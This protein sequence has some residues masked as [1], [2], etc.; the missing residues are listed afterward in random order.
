MFGK[1]SCS[2]GKIRRANKQSILINIQR[3]KQKSNEATQLK[4]EHKKQE[5]DVI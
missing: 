1:F 5:N 4:K 3:I 2:K